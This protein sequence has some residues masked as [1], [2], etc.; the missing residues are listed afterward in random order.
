MRPLPPESSPLPRAGRRRRTRPRRP[1]SGAF[2]I[3]RPFA[4]GRE[5]LG[6]GAPS[7]GV[8]VS[9]VEESG[10]NC[11]WEFFVFGGEGQGE[12]RRRRL[13]KAGKKIEVHS[14]ASC[15]AA[16]AH[17]VAAAAPSFVAVSHSLRPRLASLS[18]TR[19]RPWLFWFVE[20]VGEELR[21]ERRLTGEKRKKK[22][23][24]MP[25]S[26]HSNSS[27]LNPHLP[28]RAPL[29]Q[30]Q[31]REGLCHAREGEQEKSGDSKG[32]KPRSESERTNSPKKE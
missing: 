29:A 31:R 1:R 30:G 16:L 19:T 24:L 15:S 13:R 14:Y 27:R 32:E 4:S 21:V 6:G 9:L 3:P 5:P 12:K 8:P 10:G 25:F 28:L 11:C 20:R 23:V 7:T 17:S 26:S 18:A 2:S 22:K